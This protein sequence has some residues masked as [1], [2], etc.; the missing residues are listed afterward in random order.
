MKNKIS[1]NIAKEVVKVEAA[2]LKAATKP[3]MPLDPVAARRASELAELQLLL[4]AT[5]NSFVSLQ[6]SFFSSPPRPWGVRACK[7]ETV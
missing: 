1:I 5:V 7:G 4:S 6:Q 3:E 2:A